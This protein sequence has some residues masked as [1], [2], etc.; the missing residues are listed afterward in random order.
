MLKQF[1]CETELIVVA[2]ITAIVLSSTVNFAGIAYI[3]SS[4]QEDTPLSFPTQQFYDAQHGNDKQCQ[5]SHPKQLSKPIPRHCHKSSLL[6]IRLRRCDS[7]YWPTS[8]K[9]IHTHF[10]FTPARWQNGCLKNE[11][12]KPNGGIMGT[13]LLNQEA[14]KYKYTGIITT[15]NRRLGYRN[16]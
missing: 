13:P 12:P 8:Q 7:I 16:G 14:L 9:L 5:T 6:K 10:N 1:T 4:H 2:W 3:W 15:S 11:T